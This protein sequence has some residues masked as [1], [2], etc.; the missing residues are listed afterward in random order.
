M[1]VNCCEIIGKVK[2]IAIDWSTN[3]WMRFIFRRVFEAGGGWTWTEGRFRTAPRTALVTTGSRCFLLTCLCPL[4][5]SANL[6][7]P[8]LHNRRSASTRLETCPTRGTS[9][10][11]LRARSPRSKSSS[12]FIQT[13]YQ[14]KNLWC[15][16]QEDPEAAETDLNVLI[17]FLVKG[18]CSIL[19]QPLCVDWC[20]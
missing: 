11:S 18:H 8:R 7:P 14:D 19:L 20:Q 10:S 15:S 17:V 1:G 12:K 5:W 13:E 6:F 16:G 4:G 9:L 2:S 3:Y